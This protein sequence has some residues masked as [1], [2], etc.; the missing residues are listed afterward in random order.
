MKIKLVLPVLVSFLLPGVTL[1]ADQERDRDRDQMGAQM[2][3]QMQE[4]HEA[5]SGDER[6]MRRQVFGWQLMTPKEREEFRNR[7]RNAKTQEER[8]RVRAENHERMKQRAQAQGLDFPDKPPSWGMGGGG[9]ASEPG[10]GGGSTGGGGGPR[11]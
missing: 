11:R 8:E 7:M 6:M 2:G 3:E 1:A 9:F 5:M 4:Q 10:A